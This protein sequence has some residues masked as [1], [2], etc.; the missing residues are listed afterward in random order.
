MEVWRYEPAMV[1]R[2]EKKDP[3]V[4]IKRVKEVENNEGKV[5]YFILHLFNKMIAGRRE[6]VPFYGSELEE[7]YPSSENEDLEKPRWC[8]VR[9][10]FLIPI[11][12]LASKLIGLPFTRKLGNVERVTIYF[13]NERPDLMF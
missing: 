7:S 13:F 8:T 3:A 6:F 1:S 4:H 2:K 10:N 11:Y 9:N 12:G 5:N